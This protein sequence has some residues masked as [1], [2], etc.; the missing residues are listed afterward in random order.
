MV[1]KPA[2]PSIPTFRTQYAHDL[3]AYPRKTVSTM[4]H[5]GT[6]RASPGHAAHQLAHT[7]PE[8]NKL[9]QRGANAVPSA[10][11]AVDLL[12]VAHAGAEM[13]GVDYVYNSAAKRPVLGLA[14]VS[15]ALVHPCGCDPVP[16]S[17]EP[18]MTRTLATETYPHRS[19]TKALLD[20]LE[21]TRVAGLGVRGVVVDSQFVTLESLAALQGKGMS[22]VGR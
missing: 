5:H 17:L 19:P 20:T 7:A 1:S 18:F 15:S 9:Q 16:L 11:L 6:I 14:F 13:Q 8:P 3:T 2:A 12:T 22:L 10:F 21:T 4:A